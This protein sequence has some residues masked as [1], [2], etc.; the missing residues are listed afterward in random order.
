LWVAVLL[1]QSMPY[2]ASLYLSL[3]NAQPVTR[4]VPVAA[5]QPQSLVVAPAITADAISAADRQV[6]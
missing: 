3:V 4:P 6:A 2:V 1:V 5:P